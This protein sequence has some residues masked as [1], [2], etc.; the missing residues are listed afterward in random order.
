M[1]GAPPKGL[2]LKG[3]PSIHGVSFSIYRAPNADA[4]TEPFPTIEGACCED[5]SDFALVAALP[6][7]DSDDDMGYE[8]SAELPHRAANQGFSGTFMSSSHPRTGASEPIAEAHD[9]ERPE[10][11]PLPQVAL[12]REENRWRPCLHATCAHSVPIVSC[13][14]PGTTLLSSD[15][16]Q[17]GGD[18][19]HRLVRA[20]RGVA[21]VNDSVNSRPIGEGLDGSSSPKLTESELSLPSP[22]ALPYPM[23]INDSE[24]NGPDG[25]DGVRVPFR[26]AISNELALAVE[27]NSAPSAHLHDR[28]PLYKALPPQKCISGDPPQ[29][30][31]SSADSKSSQ[32]AANAS[33]SPLRTDS[34]SKRILPRRPAP[35]PP[36]A[37]SAKLGASNTR[38]LYVSGRLGESGLACPSQPLALGPSKR[39]RT[40]TQ[41]HALLAMQSTMR[42]KQDR[43]GRMRYHAGRPNL[44]AMFQEVEDEAAA[45]GESKV[46]LLV[47]GNKG[48]LESCLRIARTR[49]GKVHFD[50]H[51]EA[52]GF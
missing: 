41:S 31:Q 32:L 28:L 18:G 12:K 22:D 33:N 8:A 47:C 15:R 2:E 14:T 6:D 4:A 30:V 24:N 26:T 19:L 9:E 44:D 5:E 16:R 36:L 3:S 23:Q 11:S 48:V 38:N 34:S 13:G 51:Y 29:P 7:V 46:A 21:A 42:R 49:T 45:L 1:T 27:D 43:N 40:G 20:H 17:S 52:F 25:D 39:I 50:P 37:L 35:P 10:M